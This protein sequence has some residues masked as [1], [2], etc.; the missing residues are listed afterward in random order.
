MSDSI[1]SS[2]SSIA[3]SGLIFS[4][5]GLLLSASATIYVG[6]HASLPSPR[7]HKGSSQDI[8]HDQEDDGGDEE[9][10]EERLSSA[11][12]WLFPIMGSCVLVGL[13]LV[14][15][16]WCR[17]ESQCSKHSSDT[18]TQLYSQSYVG[19]LRWTVGEARW[20]SYPEL[21]VVFKQRQV[22]SASQTEPSSQFSSGS[23]SPVH[24]PVKTKSQFSVSPLL[25]FKVPS[26]LLLPFSAAPSLL[27]ILRPDRTALLTNLLGIAF[28]QNAIAL[29]KLDG[30]RTGCILLSALFFYD[31][32]WVFGTRVMVEVATNLDVPIKL[33]MPKAAQGGYT[34]LGLGDIVIPGV[35]I[36]LCLRFDHHRAERPVSSTFSRPYFLANLFAYIS[37]LVTTM[38]V[39]HAFGKAQPALLYLSPACIGAFLLTAAFRNELS[40]AWKWEDKSTSDLAEELEEKNK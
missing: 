29:L 26:L 12:A 14:I 9:E 10:S 8:D 22:L 36:A 24:A 16:H 5:A 23:A 17:V 2:T 11:D 34:M 32:W 15:K 27:Y 18:F 20:R 38:I 25:T 33:I 31:I 6:A 19:L 3:D 30:F 39:M 13:Y 40:V 35:F 7:K 28:A 21:A 4:Y 37:G 1:P